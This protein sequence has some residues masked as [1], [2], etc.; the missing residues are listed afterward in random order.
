M[1]KVAETGGSPGV[2][3][4]PPPECG[5]A[6]SFRKNRGADPWRKMRCF[7]CG[8]LSLNRQHEHTVGLPEVRFWGRILCLPH[9]AFQEEKTKNMFH[10]VSHPRCQT[11]L[12]TSTHTHPPTHPPHPHTHTHTPTPLHPTFGDSALTGYDPTLPAS[13]RTRNYREGL[14]ESFRHAGGQSSRWSGVAECTSSPALACRWSGGIRPRHAGWSGRPCNP[15]ISLS[16]RSR[17]GHGL[18]T[19]TGGGEENQKRASDVGTRI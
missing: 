10:R 5:K 4:F 7:W 9:G 13:S 14:D 18:A 8:L 15:P 2:M 11:S 12:L 6:T 16:Q 1:S 19:N 17:R 3:Q